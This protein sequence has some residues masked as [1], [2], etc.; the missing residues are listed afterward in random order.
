MKP[1]F[2]IGQKVFY[3]PDY[4]KNIAPKPSEIVKIHLSNDEI[5][6]TLLED[7][8]LKE[9]RIYGSFEE[10]EEF[11]RNKLEIILEKLKKREPYND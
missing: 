7:Y 9:S 2:E 6:Y 11:C 10:I 5:T 3:E 8:Y 4:P 1:K